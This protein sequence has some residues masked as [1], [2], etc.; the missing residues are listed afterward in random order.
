ME[1]LCKFV[2][3]NLKKEHKYL[4][5]LNLKLFSLTLYNI[6]LNRYNISVPYWLYIDIKP[7]F[8]LWLLIDIE[9]V[10]FNLNYFIDNYPIFIL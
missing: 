1:L 6:I 4:N 9:F 5:V 2:A 8:Y 7:F 10:E 3:Y